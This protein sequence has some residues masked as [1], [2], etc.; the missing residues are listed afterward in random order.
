MDPANL[1]AKEGIQRIEKQT[2]NGLEGSYD[3]EVEDME[4]S[5]NDGN[6]PLVS[7][8]NFFFFCLIGK[9]NFSTD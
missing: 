7:W 6:N 5:D 9:Y 1:P 8:S 2:D 3:V 4:G